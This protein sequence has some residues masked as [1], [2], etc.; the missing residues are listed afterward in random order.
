MYFPDSPL[1][2]RSDSRPY[3]PA[4]FPLK[5]PGLPDPRP[6]GYDASHVRSNFRKFTPSSLTCSADLGTWKWNVDPSP[7][8]RKTHRLRYWPIW[9]PPRFVLS[10]L[11][12]AA[13]K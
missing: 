12:D 9:S 5:P 13:T 10:L 4:A 7:G 11:L 1:A 3:L 8:R 2:R 6:I